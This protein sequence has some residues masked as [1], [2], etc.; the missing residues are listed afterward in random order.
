MLKWGF[1]SLILEKDELNLAFKC[2]EYNKSVQSYGAEVEYEFPFLQWQ[3]L[4]KVEHFLSCAESC[5][6][7]QRRRRESNS[8]RA[9]YETDA[10]R[11]QLRWKR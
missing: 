8:R 10:I 9:G 7:Q 11:T 3:R 4:K 5:W 1:C 6:S 2:L